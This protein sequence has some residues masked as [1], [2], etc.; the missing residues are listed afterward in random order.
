MF[1][2]NY[3]YVILS[4]ALF[5]TIGI[6]SFSQ[7]GHLKFG[8]IDKAS[9]EMEVYEK[10][11]SASAVILADYGSTEIKYNTTNE[12]FYYE[13]IRHRRIKIL[14]KD[15]YDWA[16][17]KVLL[18]H[19]NGKKEKISSINGYSYNLENGKI[20]KRKLEKDAIFREKSSENW[21]RLRFALPNV[22]EGAVIEYTYHIRSPFIFNVQSWQ[23]QYSIPSVWSEYAI[24]VPEYFNFKKLSQGYLP[25]SSYDN[26]IVNG[27][28]TFTNK[29]RT[30]QST[31]VKTTYSTSK[32]DYKKYVD[33]WIIEDVP[34][35]NPEKFLTTSKDYVSKIDFE[36]ASVQFPNSP[37]EPI[38][39]TWEKLIQKL[40]ESEEF[41]VQL[42]KCR[43]VKDQLAAIEANNQTAESKIM[44]ICDHVKN[45]VLWNNENRIYIT[46]SLAS[47]YDKGSGN[48][49]DINLLLVCMLKEAGFDADPVIL[50]TRNHGRISEHLSPHL[51]KFNYVIAH[52]SE[53]DKEY[54]L[55]ATDKNLP[56]N[57]LPFNCLN[58]KG[59]LVKKTGS[60]WIDLRNNEKSS[61]R[62]LVSLK[63]NSD[64][65]VEGEI[66]KTYIGY[67]A[68]GLRDEYKKLGKK[69]F[70]E[71]LI[72]DNENLAIAN[73]TL[74]NMNTPN[75][76]V[77]IEYEVAP[78]GYFMNAGKMIYIDPLLDEKTK[79]NPFKLEKREYPVDFGCPIEEVYMFNLEIPEGYSVEELP[80]TSM[81]SLPNNGGVFKYSVSTMNNKISILSVIKIK[82]S[83][84]LPNEYSH[85]KKFYDI[86]IAK[87]SEKIVLKQEL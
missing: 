1:K 42:K 63:F 26:N 3:K 15:G 74:K 38:M 87:Q 59:R 85:I 50:S 14:K 28:I 39:N 16:N 73:V 33:K 47:A 53:G 25:F 71:D 45:K 83:L 20:V 61:H 34:A 66:E 30:G 40:L 23:F 69:E 46:T 80:K 31:V 82:Q 57:S 54:L 84:F 75:D 11:T 60:R 13:F 32:I 52:V 77:K 12:S 41:G 64:G 4:L 58:G 44:A 76:N 10:D 9:L 43:F 24:S 70:V 22:K 79:D 49:A 51:S 37:I 19:K 18:Y 35:F 48:S 5:I 67:D 86:I 2:L 72:N 36:L 8:K 55:D 6:D 21:D 29:S 78:E 17:H 27:S 56:I 81:V 62:I 65:E 68:L 7:N